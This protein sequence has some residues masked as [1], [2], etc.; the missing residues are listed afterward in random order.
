MTAVEIAARAATAEA[1]HGG[2]GG[3]GNGGGRG[4]DRAGDAAAAGTNTT[5]R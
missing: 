4:G 1:I 5:R 2:R 3:R